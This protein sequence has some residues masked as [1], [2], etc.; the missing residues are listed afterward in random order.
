MPAEPEVLPEDISVE[1]L[2]ASHRINII[3]GLVGRNPPGLPAKKIN[4]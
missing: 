3:Y 1:S 4:L 2:L